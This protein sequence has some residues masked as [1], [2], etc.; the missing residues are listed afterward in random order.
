MNTKQ[1]YKCLFVFMFAFSSCATRYELATINRTRILID[2]KYD[3]TP[4]AQA[5]AFM[6]K[7]K[8]KVDSIMAPIVG[9]T[10]MPL[11]SYRPE[12]PLSNLLSDILVWGSKPYNEKIDFA[13]YNIGGIRA[14]FAKGDITVGD[15]VDVAPFENKICLLTLK[16]SKVLELFKQIAYTGGEG[17]S[18]SVRL[19]IN[20]KGQLVS[21]LINGQPVD[22]DKNYRIVTLDYLAQGNDKLEAFKSKTNVISP[23]DYHSNVR[24]IIIDYF[25]EMAKEGKAVS[26]QKEGR[27]TIVP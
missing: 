26:A 20:N 8:Q 2:N 15:V 9:K 27:I 18:S 16:G 22:K 1:F 24:F 10:S 21:A 3:A 7:Y 14:S 4:D 19:K 13:V 17:V 5:N 23:Q 11:A 25:K 12:S 6:S